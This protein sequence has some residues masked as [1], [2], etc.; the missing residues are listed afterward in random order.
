MT[1]VKTM[2]DIDSLFVYAHDV[3]TSETG[4]YIRINAE[5]IDNG[6]FVV[7]N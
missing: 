2:V 3:A 4:S 6:A 5:C 1:I 7:L